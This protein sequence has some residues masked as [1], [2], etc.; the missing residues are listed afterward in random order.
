MGDGP[1]GQDEPPSDLGVSET[2]GH[3]NEH[4]ELARRRG[5]PDSPSSPAA[6]PGTARGRRARAGAARRRPPRASRRALGARRGRP[7][8]RS[9]HRTPRPQGPPR[10]GSRL[11]AMPP[12]RRSSRRG[13]AARTDRAASAGIGLVDAALA[14]PPGELG[15]HP[16]RAEPHASSKVSAVASAIASGAT[17]QPERLGLGGRDLPC[18][19]ELPRPFGDL[20]RLG[21]RRPRI[22]IASARTQEREHDREPGDTTACS[23]PSTRARSSPP[24]G[25]SRRA[26]ARPSSVWRGESAPRR[27][28]PAPRSRRARAR[29]NAPSDRATVRG[30]RP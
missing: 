12:R 5:S 30:S 4:L 29:R 26:R 6:G 10:R 13:A 23:P 11:P 2:L 15:D 21:E 19:P 22:G 7:E 14:A 24:P 9:R 17:C 27:Q 25:P 20:A 8:A 1:L 28:G 18:P 16:R 3:Q